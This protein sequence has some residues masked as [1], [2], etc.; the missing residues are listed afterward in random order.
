VLSVDKWPYAQEAE[1][2]LLLDAV[3]RERLV[4]AQQ[5][6]KSLAGAVVV[7]KVWSAAVSLIFLVVQSSVNQISNP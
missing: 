4:K 5:A 3:G 6:G 1:K 7:Y 2:S